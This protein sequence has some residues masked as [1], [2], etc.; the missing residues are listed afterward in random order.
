MIDHSEIRRRV[1]SSLAAMALV[2]SAASPS[3]AAEILLV[4]NNQNWEEAIADNDDGELGFTESVGNA[5][6]TS[7]LNLADHPIASG[8]LSPLT[9]LE[10]PVTLFFATS[11]GTGVTTVALDFNALSVPTGLPAQFF[12]L[13]EN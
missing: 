13:R 4:T 10:I 11:P 9:F 2:A 3:Q 6:D 8:L 12:V 5:G 7:Q 1:V